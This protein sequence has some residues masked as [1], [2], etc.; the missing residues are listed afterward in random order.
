MKSL[1]QLTK[2]PFFLLL[3]V[4]VGAATSLGA[5]EGKWVSLFDGK[6]LNGWEVKGGK[7]KYEVKEGA[8]VG[9]TVEGSP[10]TFLCTTQSYG[11]FV[12][13]CQALCD[14]ELNSGFQIRSHTY[15]KD[16]LPP[17]S[18]KK[19]SRPAGTVHGYQ[20]EIAAQASGN[21]GNFWDEAR[22]AMWLDDLSKKPEAQKAFKDGEWNTYRIVAQGD[23]IQSWVNGIACAD[24]RDSLDATGFIGLQVHGIRAGIGPFQVRF[25]NIR[26]R[27][28]K[29]GEKP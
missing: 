27:E 25:K 10:N 13:E 4:T 7:A 14:K 2:I 19:K 3:T 24:F 21:C 26:I 17:D 22:R 20:C 8:I 18:K 16:T 1:R 12:F 29:P 11:D 28:L 23:R 15:D 6:T 9:T 5:A